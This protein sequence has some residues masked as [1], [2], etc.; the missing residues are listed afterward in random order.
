[1]QPIY[2][3]LRCRPML[4]VSVLPSDVYSHLLHC[5][6]AKSLTRS[7][8]WPSSTSAACSGSRHWER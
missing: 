4:S 5:S 8:V 1:M 7:A 6:S 3:T 2:V